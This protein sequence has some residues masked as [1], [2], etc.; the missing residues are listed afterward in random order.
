MEYTYVMY[1]MHPRRSR[2]KT[3]AR[4][5]GKGKHRYGII[6]RIIA[7]HVQVEQF[8]ARLERRVPETLTVDGLCIHVCAESSGVGA[9]RTEGPASPMRSLRSSL[10]VSYSVPYERARG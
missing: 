10:Q 4:S 6:I 3:K 7:Q 5:E 9:E 2:T 8:G 1:A